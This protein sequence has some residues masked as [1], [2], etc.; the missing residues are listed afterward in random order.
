MKGQSRKE[1]QPRDPNLVRI[2]KHIADCGVASRRKAEEMIEE[3]RVKVNN[4]VVTEPGTKIDPRKDRVT[5]NNRPLHPVEKGILLLH[6]PRGVVST[7]SDP[8]GR[9]TVGDFLTRHYKSYFPVGRL[10]WDSSGLMIMTN[11]GELAEKL[12]H[13]RY[14]YDRTYHVRVSGRVTED[15]F[16]RI[17]RGVRLKDGP[18][19]A[20]ARF[21][22]GDDDSTWLEITVQ[23]GRNRLVRR[24]M[25]HVRH[26]VMKLRRVSYGPFKLGKLQSGEMRRLTEN[27]YQKIRLKVLGSDTEEK[28]R[29]RRKSSPPRD[30]DDT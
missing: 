14:G 8:E 28:K 6:K 7:L 1:K 27:E 11:D 2:H 30:R 21:L 17:E 26:P 19:T 22:R 5:V 24:L 12:M 15:T 25:E 13:P 9:P 29:P 4:K 10:D 3:G 18:V 20:Q 23:E 16:K